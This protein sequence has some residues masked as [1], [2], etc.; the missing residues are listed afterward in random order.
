MSVKTIPSPRQFFFECAKCGT[1]PVSEKTLRRFITP[2][3]RKE[4]DKKLAS[5]AGGAVLKF[6]NGCP[7]CTPDNPHA[8]VELSALKPIVH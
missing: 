3:L 7:A 4:L 2:K 8:K 1:Y 6:L 5:G